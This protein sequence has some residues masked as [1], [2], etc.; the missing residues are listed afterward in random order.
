M[1]KE[2]LFQRFPCDVIFAIHNRPSLAVGKFAVRAGPITAGGGFFD[3]DIKGVGAHGARPESGIDPVLIAAH[4]TTALQSIVSRN[5][6]P[7]EAAVVSVTKIVAGDAYN[8]IPS[9]ARLSGTVRA[10]STPA[11][12]LM[13]ANLVRISEGV[14]AAM[15]ATAEVDFRMIFVP[16][17]NDIQEAEFAARVCGEMVGAEN[18]ARDPALAMGSE[19]FSFMLHEVPGCYINI[20]NGGED[21]VGVCEVHNPSYDFNDAALPLGASFFAHLVERRLAGDGL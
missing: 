7:L 14:A 16:T 6:H 1:I 3:I 12:D 8:V 21:G 11:L 15:G 17:V 19:D 9:T 20:G 18:V 2:G 10:F 13:E 5:V 4:V